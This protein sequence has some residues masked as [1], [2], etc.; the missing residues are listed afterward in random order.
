MQ[1]IYHWYDCANYK[2]KITVSPRGQW[3]NIPSQSICLYRLYRSDYHM[4][5]SEKIQRTEYI[6]DMRNFASAHFLPLWLFHALDTPPSFQTSMLTQ[7]PA[8]LHVSFPTCL[9]ISLF[10][11]VSVCSVYYFLLTYPSDHWTQNYGAGHDSLMSSQFFSFSLSANTPESLSEGASKTAVSAPP[12]NHILLGGWPQLGW[13]ASGQKVLPLLRSHYISQH[14]VAGSS[15]IWWENPCTR[16]AGWECSIPQIA[17]EAE[18]HFPLENK[19]QY[20]VLCHYKVINFV[21][22]SHNRHPIACLW[23]QDMGCLLWVQ[24]D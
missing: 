20:T 10:P 14:L 5:F 24:N 2:F 18:I 9:P 1:D 17:G 21:K 23:G 8:L 15:L 3:V 13:A 11:P 12:S 7:W 4:W 22:N 16:T 19:K 6:L